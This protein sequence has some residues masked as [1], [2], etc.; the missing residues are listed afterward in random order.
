VK[1]LTLILLSFLL[2][3]FSPAGAQAGGGPSKL[4]PL[5]RKAVREER[6]RGGLRSLEAGTSGVHSVIA[7]APS[8]LGSLAD[9]FVQ[10]ADVDAAAREVVVVGGTVGTRVGEFFTASIP[11][12]ALEEVAGHPSV[13][14]L[15]ASILAHPQLNVS[16]PEVKVDAILAGT[17]LPRAIRGAGVVVGVVDTGIDWSHGDFKTAAGSR[18]QYLWDMS[19][20][21]SPPAGYT[22]GREYTKAQIDAGQCLEKDGV[23]G[24]GHGTHVSGTA[25]GN[26]ATLAGYSGM[27]P[28]ADIVFVKGSTDPDSKSLVSSAKIVD[29]CAY[30]FSKAGAKPAVINLSLGSGFGSH[31]GMSSYEQ[32]MSGLTGPGRIIVVANGND[33]SHRYH[34]SYTADPAKVMET[35]WAFSQ[36]ATSGYADVWY[37]TGSLGIGVRAYSVANNQLSYVG[38]SAEIAPGGSLNPTPIKNASGQTLGLVSIDATSNPD[39][40]N[41]ANEVLVTIINPNEGT[42]ISETYWTLYA[43]GTGTLDAWTSGGSFRAEAFANWVPGDTNKTVGVPATAK[44]VIAVGAY[45]T[46]DTWTDVDGRSQTVNSWCADPPPNDTVITQAACFSSHGPT[47]DGRIKPEIAAPGQF[48]LA[49]LSRDVTVVANGSGLAGVERQY[50]LSGGKYRVEQGTSMAAPH[51][52]GIVAL[53]LAANPALT[54]ETAL[55]ALQQT[56]RTDAATGAVPNNTWGAGRVDALAAVKAVAPATQPDFT[57]S[58]SPT[59]LSV[60]AGGGASSQITTAVSGGF[61]SGISLSASGLPAGATASFSPATISSPGS[62]TSTMS[63]STS[64]STPADTYDVTVTGSGGGKSHAATIF[65]AVRVSSVGPS[66]CVEDAA[67]MCLTGGRYQIRSHWKNQ[68]AGGAMSTLSKAKL[69]DVTG[70]FWIANSSTYEY[71]IRFNTAT[72]NGRVWIAIPTFTDVEFWIDVTDTR[73]GQSNEYHSPAGNRTLL[74]DTNTFVY[75]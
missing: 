3:S 8:P 17:G 32:M 47:R 49:P 33:G 48:I 27:A 64:S 26:G 22:Y 12:T 56:A 23:G 44:K 68:Y 75:P 65:L 15:Q 72:D 1:K 11:V 46:K 38:Q 52:T 30:I 62:G 70:A 54:Y 28:E 51:I 20:T 45:V 66:S 5:L 36:G 9:V 7:L 60:T 34:V 50:V 6:E 73:T 74:Y 67:T 13:A 41:G 18:I 35:G 69:T 59:S 19:G 39:P 16:R 25:A 61:S 58:A 14:S 71:L 55:A 4:D 43:H 10:A 53:L 29:A 21:S 63:I 24:G 31:D 2:F 37:N 57:I 40:S 42:D